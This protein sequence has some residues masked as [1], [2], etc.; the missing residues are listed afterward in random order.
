MDLSES[1]HGADESLF[2]A[3]NLAGTNLG[4]DILMTV[5]TVVGMTYVL[6]FLI[7]ALWWSGRRIPAFDIAVLIAASDILSE[8]LKLVFARTRPFEALTD[9]HTLD[10]DGLTSASGFSFPSGHA[11]RAFAVGFYLLYSSQ[12]RFRIPAL[13]VPILI[14]L[15]RVYLGLH[16]PSD[17]LGGAIIGVAIAVIVRWLGRREGAY[18]LGRERIVAAIHGR[19]HR[20][21]GNSVSPQV[22]LD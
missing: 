17:I 9:V 13:V 10:W 11:V 1:F 5:L 14:S 19:F 16:W 6:I 18:S 2:R 15:S 21:K 7:P 8:T 12:W 3:L 20:R 4:L 22:K